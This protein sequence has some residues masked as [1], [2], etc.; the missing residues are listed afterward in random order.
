MR[1]FICGEAWACVTWFAVSRAE[2]VHYEYLD[3]LSPRTTIQD[4]TSNQGP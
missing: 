4:S 3:T 2:V 1:Y